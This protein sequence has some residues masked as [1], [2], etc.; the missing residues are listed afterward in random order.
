[1]EDRRKN[2]DDGWCDIES[3]VRVRR[4][5]GVAEDG[6][7]KV[8]GQSDGRGGGDDEANLQLRAAPTV[9]SG[10]VIGGY[11]GGRLMRGLTGGSNLESMKVGLHVP[12]ER[13]E[14]Y[15]FNRGGWGRVG[16]K[17]S[18]TPAFLAITSD[19]AFRK[20]RGGD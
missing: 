8:I 10:A 11:D 17:S 2:T 19:G 3:P 16:K 4:I 15:E 6:F 9:K 13:F 5:L 14:I 7:F 20:K 1:M 12:G 18:D